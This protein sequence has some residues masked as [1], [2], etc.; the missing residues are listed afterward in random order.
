[1]GVGCRLVIYGWGLLQETPSWISLAV[2][3]RFWSFWSLVVSAIVAEGY[4]SI[5]E[6][7]FLHKHPI[8]TFSITLLIRRRVFRNEQSN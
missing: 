2:H 6:D 8:I 7:I 5:Q 3:G 4:K 1:M